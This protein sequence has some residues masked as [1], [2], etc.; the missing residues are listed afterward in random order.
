[1][2]HSWEDLQHIVLEHDSSY[3]DLTFGTDALTE[4]VAALG[5]PPWTPIGGLGLTDGDGRTP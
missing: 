5:P 1:M 3:L 2:I 4:L